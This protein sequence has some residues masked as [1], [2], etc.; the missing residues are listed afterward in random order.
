MPN[1]K[2]LTHEILAVVEE[3]L[4]ELLRAIEAFEVSPSRDGLGRWFGHHAA[5]DVGLPDTPRRQQR[6][7]LNGEHLPV[8]R[9]ELVSPDDVVGAQRP[10]RIDGEFHGFNVRHP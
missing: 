6:Q 1:A 10:A 5:A 3:D 2:A 7:R 4:D 9:D 8:V